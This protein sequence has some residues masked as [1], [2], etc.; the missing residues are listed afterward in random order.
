[1]TFTQTKECIV[2]LDRSGLED[3]LKSL[4]EEIIEAG[5]DCDV[6]PDNIEEAYQGEFDNDSDFAEQ[7]CNDIYDL[8]NMGNNGGWHPANYIDWERVAHDLMLDYCESN[9]FYFRNL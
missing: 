2:A 5:L 1:M 3:L 8:G 9:G 7:T 4:S 6:A